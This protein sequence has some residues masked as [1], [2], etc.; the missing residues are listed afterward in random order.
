[1]PVPDLKNGT[2]VLSYDKIFTQRYESTHCI[3]YFNYQVLLQSEKYVYFIIYD[4]TDEFI[5]YFK[6]Y[7]YT[8]NDVNMYKEIFNVQIGFKNISIFADDILVREFLSVY[9]SA[10]FLLIKLRTMS[11]QIPVTDIPKIL[12]YKFNVQHTKISQQNYLLKNQIKHINLNEINKYLLDDSY[13]NIN[14]EI[15]LV[16]SLLL[17][18]TNGRLL[19][20]IDNTKLKSKPH[21]KSNY[22]K[23]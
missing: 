6:Q 15:I 4:I 9:P 5:T 12:D 23:K 18:L 8:P 22:K 11:I 17:Y 1:M 21:W 7:Q 10:V 20:Y 2:S 3:N 13:E 16:L 19:E 14:S